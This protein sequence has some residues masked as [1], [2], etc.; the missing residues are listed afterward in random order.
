M[1]RLTSP[2]GGFQL[3]EPSIDWLGEGPL[4]ASCALFCIPVSCQS[5]LSDECLI[6][7]IMLPQFKQ[8]TSSFWYQSPKF[9]SDAFFPATICHI[10]QRP[11][12]SCRQIVRMHLAP[13]YV[14]E[15][16]QPELDGACASVR[17]GISHKARR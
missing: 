17:D 12:V 1:L 10:A 3:L 6:S 13:R 2:I 8:K 16:G 7:S 11:R 9:S 14:H 15:H 4:L 5:G